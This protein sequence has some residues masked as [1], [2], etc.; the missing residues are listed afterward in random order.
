MADRSWA[1]QRKLMRSPNTGFNAE[2]YHWFK[3]VED[4]SAKIS[5]RK[6]LRDSLL[7]QAKESRTSAMFK[8]QYFREFVQQTHLKPDVYGT[9]ITTFHESF[10]FHPQVELVFSQDSESIPKGRSRIDG[11][12][13]FRLMGETAATITRS[14]ALSLATKIANTLV[15]GAARY[16]Y[17]KGKIITSYTDIEHGYKLQIYCISRIEGIEVIKKVLSIQDHPY[18]EGFLNVSTPEKESDNNPTGTHLVYGEQ[19]K[20]PRWRPTANVYFRYATLKLSGLFRD[21][22]LVD[23]TG[24]YRDALV[25]K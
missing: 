10:L 6:T 17:S 21:V 16:S 12:I 11:E 13:N 24:R 15:S 22:V 4:E 14:K 20:K 9:P 18:N 19:V 2:V 23:T 5:S 3:D 1:L 8:I 25:R 7:I